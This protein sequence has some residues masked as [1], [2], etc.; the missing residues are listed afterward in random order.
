MKHIGYI[1]VICLLVLGCI[2][3]THELFIY[4]GKLKDMQFDLDWA[5]AEKKEIVKQLVMYKQ[6]AGYYEYIISRG[7][8]VN[9][10]EKIFVEK[11]SLIIPPYEKL[12]P[13]KDE[14]Q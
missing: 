3:L 4:Q 7:K 6:A 1:I 11:G 13:Q 2:Y 9:K 5:K 10:S 14:K 12:F 8:Q